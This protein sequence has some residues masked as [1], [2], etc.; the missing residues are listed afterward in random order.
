[1]SKKILTVV[2][3]GLVLLL[4][5]EANALIFEGRAIGSWQNVA[6]DNPWDGTQADYPAYDDVSPVDP[7]YA[8]VFYVDNRDAGHIATF[9]W[10]EAA[11]DIDPRTTVN[12]FLFNG[13]GS[14]GAMGTLDTSNTSLVSLGTFDYQNGEVW[15]AETL[16]GV[17]LKIDFTMR[18]QSDPTANW[19]F[20]LT[21]SFSIVNTL[22]EAGNSPDQNADTVKLDAGGQRIY[23]FTYD[24][25]D[26]RFEIMGFSR[27]DGATIT[28]DFSSWENHTDGA[29]L[30]G[31]IIE[32]VPEPSTV[33][34]FGVGLVGL[35]GLRKKADG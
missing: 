22:N 9:I 18:V 21:N 11:L 1:M 13:S 25:R 5:L 16:H 26:Y 30:Y 19:T 3:A 27:D 2:T 34:L 33:L 7:T 29:K 23:D 24:S 15:Y 32:P 4:A 28:Q 6:A 8:D 10:G 31:R 14:D 35:L 17:D 12:S 20:D